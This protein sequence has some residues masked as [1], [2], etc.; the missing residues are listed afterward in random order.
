MYNSSSTTSYLAMS[1]LAALSSVNS[2]YSC[3]S[4]PLLHR[5]LSSISSLLPQFVSFPLPSSLDNFAWNWTPCSHR[6]PCVTLTASPVM[7]PL[8]EEN[9]RSFMSRTS[10]PFASEEHNDLTTFNAVHLAPGAWTWKTTRHGSEKKAAPS[11]NSWVPNAHALYR[12]IFYMS[13]QT[14]HT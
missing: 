13:A 7:F 3:N 4:F 6:L 5:L 12:S 10:S 9:S 2:D 1:H 8:S 14:K 11:Q